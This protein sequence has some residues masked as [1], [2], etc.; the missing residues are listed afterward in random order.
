MLIGATFHH[1]DITVLWVNT[2]I[3]NHLAHIDGGDGIEVQGIKGSEGGSEG[4]EGVPLFLLSGH[5]KDHVPFGIEPDSS[6]VQRM[7]GSQE[8]EGPEVPDLRVQDNFESVRVEFAPTI[9]GELVKL[10]DLAR[11]ARIPK[12][13]I[14]KDQVIGVIEGG[15]VALIMIRGVVIKCHDCLGSFC[16]V[17]PRDR[18]LGRSDQPIIARAEEKRVIILKVVLININQRNEHEHES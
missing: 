4:T 13:S 2:E 9:I 16:G 14:V 18:I 1:R 10:V 3:I 5:P 6:F 7:A 12:D 15:D 17:D 11:G 8:L